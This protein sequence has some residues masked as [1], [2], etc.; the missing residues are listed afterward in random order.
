MYLL[1]RQHIR[2]FV[3][4]VNIDL[5]DEPTLRKPLVSAVAMVKGRHQRC[6]ADVWI[7]TPEGTKIFTIHDHLTYVSRDEGVG[8]YPN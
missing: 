5:A 7:T 4:N 6:R 1:P 8:N 2:D 3:D